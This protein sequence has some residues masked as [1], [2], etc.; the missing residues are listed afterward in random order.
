MQP[1]QIQLMVAFLLS[2]I[3]ITSLVFGTSEPSAAQSTASAGTP[4]VGATGVKLSMID[5]VFQQQLITLL[6]H[7]DICNYVFKLT[8]EQS[9]PVGCNYQPGIH[10][11][12]PQMGVADRLPSCYIFYPIY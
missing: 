8:N 6:E 1:R 4:Y 9:C 12:S 5:I 2:L 11:P 3:I 10:R 7:I